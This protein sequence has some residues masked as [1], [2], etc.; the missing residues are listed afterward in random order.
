MDRCQELW[1]LLDCI[2]W[3]GWDGMEGLWGIG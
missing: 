1:T 2:Y 3:M